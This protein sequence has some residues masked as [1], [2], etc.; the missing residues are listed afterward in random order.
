MSLLADKINFYGHKIVCIDDEV[1][2]LKTERTNFINHAHL[3]KKDVFF[4]DAYEPTLELIDSHP[5]LIIAVV[6]IRI[7]QNSEDA[8]DFNAEN[9]D[10]EWGLKLIDE[11]YKKYGKRELNIIVVSAY[12]EYD[13]KIENNPLVKGFYRKP[14]NYSSFIQD[15]QSIV[16]NSTKRAFDYSRFDEKTSL[17]VQNKTEEIK[18]L[19]KR[20]AQDILN[21]GNYLIEIKAKLGHGNYEDWLEAEFDWSLSQAKRFTNVAKRFKSVNLTE[22]DI[23]SSA[24]YNLAAPTLPEEVAI[25]AIERAKKGEKITITIAEEIIAKHK[26]QKKNNRK[27]TETASSS[28]DTTTVPTINKTEK[29]ST[30]QKD[31]PQEFSFLKTSPIPKKI[32]PIKQEVLTVIPTDKAVTNSWWQFGER[33]KLF[34]GEPNSKQFLDKLPKNISLTVSVLPK[35]DS[36][37]IPPIELTSSASSLTFYS[38]HK[39]LLLDPMIDE[40]F[41]TAVVSNE[42]IVF[43]YIHHIEVLEVVNKLGACFFVAEPN[44]EKCDRLLNRWR[45]KEPGSVNRLKF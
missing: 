39:D 36:S 38:D 30:K 21:I 13:I 9:P 6:D 37:L 28:T 23:P 33:H 5:E 3:K 26:P 12:T 16:N 11:I 35:K 27:N 42:I 32:E 25:E 22:L 45:E 17:F 4:T 20:T 7:P 43:N 31:L 19:V 18:F 41:M 44:L 24:L 14:V 10:Q 8:H 29:D 2:P 1:A 15:L 40:A 34:C